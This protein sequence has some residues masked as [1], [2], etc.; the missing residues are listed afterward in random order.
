MIRRVC[1]GIFKVKPRAY[2]LIR[3]QVHYRRE[4]FLSG[5]IAAGYEI[6]PDSS[7]RTPIRPDD[8]LIIWNR[9]GRYEQ[10]AEQMEAGGGRVIVV[11]NGYCG[12]DY[13]SRQPYAMALGQHQGAGRWYRPPGG[14]PDWIT[15]FHALGIN[16]APFDFNRP[17]YVLICGQRSIGSRLMKSPPNWHHHIAGQINRDLGLPVEV[18]EHPELLLRAKKMPTPLHIDLD[19]ARAVVVWSSNVAITSLAMG[20]PTYYCAPHQIVGISNRWQRIGREGG[21]GN[22]TKGRGEW[23]LSRIDKFGTMAWAQWFVDEIA[24]GKPFELLRDI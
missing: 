3:T 11:E 2:C 8:L 12:K 19:G 17:G 15:R 6:M 13:N 5:L 4:A 10:M 9:Y 24:T 23:A 18:R 21:P 14:G 7:F 22:D 16:L 20:I 1:R